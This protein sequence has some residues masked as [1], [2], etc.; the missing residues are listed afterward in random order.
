[1]RSSSAPSLALLP[2][3]L[4]GC[5]QY[6]PADAAI[7]TSSDAA[8]ALEL[9]TRDELAAATT[10]SHYGQESLMG[11]HT[12]ADTWAGGESRF[13]DY[14]AMEGSIEAQVVLADA[15]ANLASVDPTVL[16][17]GDERLAYWLNLYNLATIQGV[18]AERAADPDY[19]GVSR[20]DFALFNTA[21]VSVGDEL[22]SLNQ[23]EHA[24]IRG[25][26]WALDNYFTDDQAD[27]RAQ[28]ESWH[29]DLWDGAAIDARIHVGLNCASLG[30]PDVLDGA[31]R[32][33][34]LD[35]TLDELATRF[36]DHPG[37]GAGPDGISQLFSWFTADFAG[38]HGS[39][40]AFVEQ[41][42]TGG[43]G[44]VDFDRQLEYDWGLN[45]A[46]E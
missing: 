4:I 18:L 11:L 16:A 25:D 39:V 19:P 26:A 6:V 1:M 30:C 7:H 21:Y 8:G 37:K 2:L 27:L 14:A 28:A 41:Y 33:G 31:F 46:G 9:A 40:E 15:L 5:G 44:D 34:D 45:A 13:V 42:R 24:I 17:D 43:A 36:V 3:L 38:S 10:L 35:A 32:A 29:A 22:L 23:I 12:E 20:D